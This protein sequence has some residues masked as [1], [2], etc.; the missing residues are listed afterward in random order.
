MLKKEINNIVYCAASLKNRLNNKGVEI[1]MN[2]QNLINAFNQFSNTTLNLIKELEKSNYPA[3]T[4]YPLQDS[5]EEIGLKLNLWARTQV[6]ILEN[7][8]S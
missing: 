7:E 8:N 3:D 2:K 6:L 5:F 4:E 1:T